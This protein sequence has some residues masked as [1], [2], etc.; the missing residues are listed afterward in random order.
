MDIPTVATSLLG[1]ILGG[2]L[3]AGITTH[4]LSVARDERNFLRTKLEAAYYDGIQFNNMLLEV[5]T[6]YLSYNKEEMSM[7]Q[8]M[9]KLAK[10]TTGMAKT[11][12][13]LMMLCNIYFPALMPSLNALLKVRDAIS[14]LGPIHLHNKP[15]YEAYQKIYAEFKKQVEAGERFNQAVYKEGQRISSSIWGFDPTNDTRYP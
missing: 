8:V 15:S 10:E 12:N 7:Q 13:E 4:F 11:S 14:H 6:A 1:S 3:V 9:D 2:G 5:T